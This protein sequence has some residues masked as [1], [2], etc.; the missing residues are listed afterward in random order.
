MIASAGDSTGEAL[1]VHL[2]SDVFDSMGA[3]RVDDIV[4]TLVRDV[5]TFGRST[6]GKTVFI[7][8]KVNEDEGSHFLITEPNMA[9]HL[10][11]SLLAARFAADEAG[12]ELPTDVQ[13]I[14]VD[15]FSVTFAT[16]SDGSAAAIL[17]AELPGHGKLHFLASEERLAR[18]AE[19]VPQ[20][21][22][23]C[24]QYRQKRN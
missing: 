9:E 24:R 14:A 21:L 13:P 15:A 17:T 18:L 6:D 22:D 10:A 3:F 1:D 20:A 7:E 4:G 19:I 12:E 2:A 5:V 11:A 16:G 8:V 23:L